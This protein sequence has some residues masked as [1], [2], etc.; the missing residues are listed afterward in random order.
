MPLQDVKGADTEERFPSSSWHA[1]AACSLMCGSGE[2]HLRA[3]VSTSI[4]VSMWRR[5]SREAESAW[6]SESDSV[7]WQAAQD[8]NYVTLCLRRSAETLK[9]V[10]NFWKSD[11][12]IGDRSSGEQKFTGCPVGGTMMMQM[13][14]WP[15][16]DP[17]CRRRV[18]MESFRGQ[19]LYEIELCQLL[20][21]L[22]TPWIGI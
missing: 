22:G 12:I 15:L 21:F 16:R 18:P 3:E 13:F 14:G 4:S 7:G 17:D 11:S 2:G 5:S 8:D 20:L 10:A 19:D 1:I 9:S 6:D